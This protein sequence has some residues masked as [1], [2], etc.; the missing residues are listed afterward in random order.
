MDLP[1]PGTGAGKGAAFQGA[2][3]GKKFLAT[4]RAS[5]TES[6]SVAGFNQLRHAA[7][8]IVVPMGRDDQNDSFG[9]IKAK[10]FQIAQ[11]SRRA[12][13]VDAGIDDD[14]RA[15]ADM[16]NDALAVPGAEQREFELV[17]PRR[18]FRR[19]H[20]PNDR[21]VC[22]AHSLPARR[23]ASVTAGRSRNTIW[24]T[25]FLVPAAERS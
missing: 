16:Q 13:L 7:D 24:D 19:R 6:R 17:A 12:A 10:V 11:G 18:R 4:E 5:A 23:S 14:P 21:S 25:R 22:R 20:D 9:R 2:D 8:V 1:N 15:V 3:D